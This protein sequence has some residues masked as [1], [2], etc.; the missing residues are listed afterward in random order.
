MQHGMVILDHIVLVDSRV[1]LNQ[2]M[3]STYVILVEIFAIIV[4]ICVA[5]LNMHQVLGIMVLLWI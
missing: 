1:M 2:V 4:K 5:I 3:D